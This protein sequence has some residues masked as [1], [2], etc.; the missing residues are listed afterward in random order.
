[1]RMRAK[2]YESRWFSMPIILILLS[3]LFLPNV[4]AVPIDC[5]DQL[6]NYYVSKGLPL[7]YPILPV[8][9]YSKA[10]ID[11]LNYTVVTYLIQKVAQTYESVI[12]PGANLSNVVVNTISVDLPFCAQDILFECVA[13]VVGCCIGK[14]SNCAISDF[15]P[16]GNCAAPCTT[17][18]GRMLIY[19][20]QSAPCN[21]VPVLMIAG[22]EVMPG[23]VYP[24]P[25]PCD[26][27]YYNRVTYDT[28]GITGG[29]TLNFSTAVFDYRS[30]ECE[31]SDTLLVDQEQAYC[32]PTDTITCEEARTNGQ[33]TPSIVSYRELR[34]SRYGAIHFA[35]RRGDGMEGHFDNRRLST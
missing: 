34:L 30:S 27:C 10:R 28:L 2:V 1:M 13:D 12:N 5:S 7:A 3:L 29:E 15:D 8:I 21:G 6:H 33:A 18:A 17:P 14:T 22:V 9:N 32:L 31:S 4:E 24:F 16:G 25:L 35:H 11:N 19:A 20:N 26:P 23:F